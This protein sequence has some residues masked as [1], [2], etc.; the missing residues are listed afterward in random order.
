MV[1]QLASMVEGYI[2][3]SR[4][5]YASQAVP[6]TDAQRAVMQPFFPAEILDSGSPL[7]SARRARA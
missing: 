1:S 3:D 6:L 7:R 5:K 2:S 4:K